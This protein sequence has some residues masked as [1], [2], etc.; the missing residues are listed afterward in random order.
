MENRI[1]IQ[2]LEPKAYKAMLGLEKYL[3]T[4]SL[5]DIE[6]ELI[7]IR[8]SQINGCAYCIE[9]H[10]KDALRYGETQK[11]IFA[12][13]AWWESPLFDEKEKVLLKM[14]EEITHIQQKGL[15]EHT[16]TAAQKHF[17]GNEIAAIIIQIGTINLWNRI[18]ISTHLK[19]EN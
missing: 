12:L 14:T 15:T 16:Y 11:R 13:S 19:H 5:T 10:T 7:K 18:A 2:Q 1:N 17:T 4:T 9:I 3:A 6:K 8:T